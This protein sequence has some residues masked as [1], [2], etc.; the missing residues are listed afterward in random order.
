MQGQS[1]DTRITA[2][3]E[4]PCE[5]LNGVT[6]RFAEGFLRP[7]ISPL[8]GLAKRAKLDAADAK[9][10]TFDPSRERHGSVDLVASSA[11]TLKHR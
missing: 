9:R 3:D 2:T 5:T 1:H 4:R 7:D 8:F 6:T 10:R 11:K